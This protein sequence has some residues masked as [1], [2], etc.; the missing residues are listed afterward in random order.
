[1]RGDLPV[2]P[3]DGD[4][5]PTAVSQGD[6]AGTAE[7]LLYRRLYAG[8]RNGR[9]FIGYRAGLYTVDVLYERLLPAVLGNCGATPR[10]FQLP[11]FALE[12]GVARRGGNHGLV[13]PGLMGDDAG[14]AG[15]CRCAA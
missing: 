11:A 15:G 14:S 4:E 8:G 9:T 5:W 1:H 12:K 7:R 6:L 3:R 13:W 2:D 10:S